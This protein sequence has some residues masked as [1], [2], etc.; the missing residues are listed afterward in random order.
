MCLNRIY[1]GV[2]VLVASAQ[3]QQMCL[4][5]LE[6]EA[7]VTFDVVSTLGTS[8][9]PLAHCLNPWHVVD[10]RGELVDVSLASTTTGEIKIK[11]T[12]STSLSV[13]PRNQ[14]SLKRR[15]CF[16]WSMGK[17]LSREFFALPISNMADLRPRSLSE[18]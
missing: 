18:W 11:Q 7:A 3:A 9:Q 10:H 16:S 13:L 15:G 14:G 12:I 2:L 4:Y 8:S 6:T 5:V 17:C 1:V